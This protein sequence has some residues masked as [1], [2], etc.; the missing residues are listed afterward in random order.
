[1]EPAGINIIGESNETGLDAQVLDGL[2]HICPTFFLICVV[3]HYDL[4]MILVEL[5][6]L[7]DVRMLFAYFVDRFSDPQLGLD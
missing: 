7:D 4:L 2:L 5:N 6:P 3:V 1:M